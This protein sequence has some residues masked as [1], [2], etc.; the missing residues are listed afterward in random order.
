[1]ADVH[2][3]F[4]GSYLPGGAEAVVAVSE[5]LSVGAGIEALPGCG[6]TD[7][8]WPE[9]LGPDISFVGALGEERVTPLREALRNRDPA[10]LELLDRFAD[11]VD[12]PAR[13][14]EAATG[15]PY[16]GSSRFYI[17]EVRSRRRRLEI[18]SSLPPTSLKIFG[19]A[20]WA[21]EASGIAS[22]Y[23]GRALRYGFDLASVYYHTRINLNVFH[24]QC[25]DSTNSRVY[26]VLAAGG[27]LLTEERPCITRE[28][29]PGRHLATFSSPA[30]AREKV[31]YYLNHP[32]E[33]EAL[34][35]EGQ[36]HVLAHHTIA[37]RCR[38]LLTLARPYIGRTC[39]VG[40]DARRDDASV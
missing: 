26:D 29:E 2:L 35:R 21:R 7:L 40:T 33:R 38:H 14:F 34:A 13:H 36:R 39:E 16:E 22:C 20:E 27:F 11:Q 9:R 1:M 4:D 28:F 10:Q 12:E 6:P 3:C 15:R 18:L 19:G 25:V 24:D 23:S 37:E 8:G 30:D 17:E 31:L 32:E 5:K